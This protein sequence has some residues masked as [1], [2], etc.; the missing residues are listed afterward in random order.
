[1]Q[2]KKHKNKCKTKTIKKNKQKKK[3]KRKKQTK[4]KKQAYAWHVNN[5]TEKNLIFWIFFL[6]GA[7]TKQQKTET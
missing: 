6:F 7:K 1:M 2:L 4:N 5:Q 3:Q